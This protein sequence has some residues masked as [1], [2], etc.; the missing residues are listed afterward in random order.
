MVYEV[1][2]RHGEVVL[3]GVVRAE[4][5][6]IAVEA[7]GRAYSLERAIIAARNRWRAEGR[8]LPRSS[9]TTDDLPMRERLD[10]LE[11]AMALLGEECP[12]QHA[13][14]AIRSSPLYAEWADLKARFAAIIDPDKPFDSESPGDW[15]RVF[16]RFRRWRAKLPRIPTTR[17]DNAEL[18][19]Y[20]RDGSWSE[21]AYFC[22]RFDLLASEWE[23][24]QRAPSVP[25][26]C[27][28][29][30][31]IRP[32]WMTTL[33]CVDGSPGKEPPGWL[34]KKWD[35]ERARAPPLLRSN[36]LNFMAP[37]FG[38]ERSGVGPEFEKGDGRLRPSLQQRLPGAEGPP[39]GCSTAPRHAACG[40]PIPSPA[41]HLRD[42][43]I[44]WPAQ[45]FPAN[46][47]ENRGAPALCVSGNFQG[48]QRVFGAPFWKLAV[49]PESESWSGAKSEAKL[50]KS[51]KYQGGRRVNSR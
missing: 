11:R 4:I 10:R 36:T 35:N 26:R 33:K 3:P 8:P 30:A 17:R 13:G 1:Y 50:R 14:R 28:A 2:L 42:R 38:S 21:E 47:K 22:D 6:G 7:S 45:A 27:A 34:E 37:K 41:G 40:G 39:E 5:P 48:K 46:K 32:D 25:R 31:E 12:P 24:K 20:E 19:G 18:F 44:F 16:Q 9:Y 23:Q 49:F 43:V 51:T 29:C 15:D